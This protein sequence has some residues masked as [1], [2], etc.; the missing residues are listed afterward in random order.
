MLTNLLELYPDSLL[1]EEISS[2][3]YLTIRVQKQIL[4]IPKR[5]INKNEMALLNLINEDRMNSLTTPLWEKFLN[6]DGPAPV[7]NCPFHFIHLKIEDNFD[8]KSWAQKLFTDIEEVFDIINLEKT[9]YLILVSSPL[10]D[11]F[12]EIFQDAIKKLD[13]EFETKSQVMLGQKI[14]HHS[15]IKNILSK[16]RKVFKSYL[17][18]NTNDKLASFSE[19]LCAYEINQVMDITKYVPELS[20]YLEANHDYITVIEEIYSAKANISE[21]AKK[22][23]IHRNTLLYR[24]SKF[25][26][27]TNFDLT[28][29]NDLLL[30]Y[31]VSNAI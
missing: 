22:L 27:E 14:S 9:F 1:G 12:K 31:L 21:A 23:Y 15:E 25:K 2:D 17:A 28:D 5:N 7:K 29:F 30:C 20:H 11:N 24:I 6:G 16:E 10:K 13:S 18:K 26:Q 8:Y 19:C 3:L 4:N